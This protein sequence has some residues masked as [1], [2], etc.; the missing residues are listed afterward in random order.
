MIATT[1]PLLTSSAA[2]CSEP[3][4][5]RMV[6]KSS[7]DMPSTRSVTSTLRTERARSRAG[8]NGYAYSHAPL[9]RRLQN[10]RDRLAEGIVLE[11]AEQV[12]EA[13]GGKAANVV[14][15]VRKQRL[16]SPTSAGERARRA[17][18]EKGQGAL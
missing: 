5:P 7:A 8:N 1:V 2:V 13:L 16:V 6:S 14:P 9:F 3:S 10:E 18:A 17:C 12:G 15:P 11:L 4:T